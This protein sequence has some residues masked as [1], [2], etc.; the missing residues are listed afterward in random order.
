MTPDGRTLVV[1]ADGRNA[2]VFEEARRDGPL[3]ERDEWLKDLPGYKVG[4]GTAPGR[5]YDRMGHASHG[6]TSE[7]PH[8][9]GEHAFLVGLVGELERIVRDHAFDDLVLIAP[10]RALGV[11]R[12]A[13]P[14]GLERKLKETE[15]H[16]RVGAT[17]EELHHALHALRVKSA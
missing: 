11:L 4:A 7:T 2:R 6:V 14:K 16:D 10:P 9:K 15:P 8:D 13:L 5:V 12:E 1:V 3:H 17:A